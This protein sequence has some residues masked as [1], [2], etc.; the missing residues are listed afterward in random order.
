M[1]NLKLQNWE[2]NQI[3][4]FKKAVEESKGCCVIASIKSVARSGMSRKI[5]FAYACNNQFYNI[6]HILE[7]AGYK[8]NNDGTITRR[9]CGM[10]MIFDTLYGLYHFLGISDFS[11]FACHYGTL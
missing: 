11:G 1:K 7:L 6:N 8:L 10:D 3:N 9:G 2:I 5:A 4:Q